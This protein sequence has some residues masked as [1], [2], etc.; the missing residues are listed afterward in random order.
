MQNQQFDIITEKYKKEINKLSNLLK[1][2]FYV[3]KN[4]ALQAINICIWKHGDKFDPDGK[5]HFCGYFY[6]SASWHL[7]KEFNLHKK[8]AQD[9]ECLQGRDKFSKLL[10]A[11]KGVNINSTDIQDSLNNLPEVQKNVL[12]KYFL[13]GKKL[14]EIAK[15]MSKSIE[16]IRIYRNQ[17]LENFKR[18]W[19]N[20]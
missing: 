15:E 12:T 19:K 17:G 8:N 2:K 9:I 7:I 14:A 18:G 13:E 11:D 5:M 20:D 16:M 4:N 3:S 1:K 6:R 10:M